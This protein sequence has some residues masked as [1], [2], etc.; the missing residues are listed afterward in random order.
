[1]WCGTLIMTVLGIELPGPGANFLSQ[2]VH[3]RKPI[4][5]G[6]TVTVTVK[7]AQKNSAD[8]HVKLD[9]IATNQRGEVVIEGVAEMIAPTKNISC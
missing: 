8:R 1:M 7:V 4:G 5:F 3:F 6:D 2:A 9:C